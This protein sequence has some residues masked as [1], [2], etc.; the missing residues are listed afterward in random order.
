M[1]LIKETLLKLNDRKCAYV[2]TLEGAKD[3]SHTVDS[4]LENLWTCRN[5]NSILINLFIS[6]KVLHLSL[7]A[8]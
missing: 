4:L 3:H 7:E 8:V 2:Y 6:Q 1:C 5:C